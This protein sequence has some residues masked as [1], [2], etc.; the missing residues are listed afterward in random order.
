MN[1]IAATSSSKEKQKIISENSG[2]IFFR[3]VVFAALDPYQTYKMSGNIKWDASISKAQEDDPALIVKIMGKL[4]EFAKHSGISKREKDDLSDLA[5]MTGPHAVAVVNCI[6]NKDLKC[7][8]S[9]LTF[10][11]ASSVFDELP[12]H[13]PMKGIDDYDKFYKAA[14]SRKNI[15]W[16][17]KLDGCFRY[18]TPILLADGTTMPIGQIVEEKLPVEVLSYD[19]K[20]GKVCK[21]RVVNWFNNG[22]KTNTEWCSIQQKFPNCLPAIMQGYKP[23]RKS[24]VTRSHKY[25]SGEWKD[26]QCL[27]TAF[28]IER[29]LTDIQEQVV[30]GACLGDA[31]VCFDRKHCRID[32]VH[33]KKQYQYLRIKVESLSDFVFRTS[34]KVSGYGSFVFRA[35]TC[36]LPQFDEIRMQLFPN[37]NVGKRE[38]P[39]KYLERL[40][41]LALAIWYLDDGAKS[42]S[43]QDGDA[44]SNVCPRASLFLY[45]YSQDTVERVSR[46]LVGKG[47]PNSI[48][49]CEHG[50]WITFTVDGTQAFFER[51][52]PYVP[53]C[54]SYKL[55]KSFRKRVGTIKW[56]KNKDK[57]WQ[58]YEVPVSV[59]GIT[60]IKKTSFTAYDIEVENTHNYFANGLL[61]HNCRIHAVVTTDAVTYLS[62]N[63]FVLDNFHVFDEVLNRAAYQIA[64]RTSWDTVIFDGE[65]INIQGDFSKHMSQ[66]RRLKDMDASGFRFCIFDV[67]PKF[68]PYSAPFLERYGLLRNESKLPLY[69]NDGQDYAHDLCGIVDHRCLTFSAKKLAKMA[70]DN[71]FEGIMLK[72]WDGEYADKRVNYWC[73]IKAINTEDLPVIGKVEGTGKYS[74]TL[75]SLIVKRGDIDVEVGS[76]FTDDERR[77]FWEN[78]PACIE[79]KYQEAL[80]S[81]SLRFPIF[82]RVR[83]DKSGAEQ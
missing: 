71:G 72:T 12:V 25:F 63:G 48:Y 61:V 73:K 62:S 74:G 9:V 68:R 82:V 59:S 30:L 49:T 53:R 38:I 43:K 6:L 19:E 64:M 36:C 20:T 26:A 57:N 22:L 23:T 13:H 55:P 4:E 33:S 34:Q 47:I 35:S 16:S 58:I 78:P 79:V 41:D 39:Q 31:S 56:W 69:Q 51:I 54:M 24:F 80:K 76:G 15:C 2:D 1:K 11:K 42:Q 21:Q 27:E 45:R 18:E 40:S 70:I 60:D 67:F 29:R 7:G 52:A 5:R 10:K 3:N 44:V 65:V 37:G 32:F 50:C 81:G 28:Q 77:E 14:G 83:D 17:V 8:A 66:F 46:W 75:G